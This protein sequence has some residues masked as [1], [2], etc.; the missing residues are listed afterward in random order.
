MTDPKLYYLSTGAD[1]RCNFLHLLLPPPYLYFLA[2]PE[3]AEFMADL[4]MEMT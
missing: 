2:S 4:T 3:W 1:K